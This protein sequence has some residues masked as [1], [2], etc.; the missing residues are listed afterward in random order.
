MRYLLIIL[1]AGCCCA[2]GRSDGGSRSGDSFRG[3]EQDERPYSENQRTAPQRVALRP[4]CIVPCSFERPSS[5]PRAYQP[6]HEGINYYFSAL[7]VRRRTWQAAGALQQARRID[8][9][10]YEYGFAPR[11]IRARAGERLA[12]YCTSRDTPHAITIEGYN[13]AAPVRQGM[14]RAVVFRARTAGTF[15]IRCTSCW[16]QGHRDMTATLVVEEG[17]HGHDRSTGG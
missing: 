7:A 15:T 4:A 9:E 6:V 12:L 11:C 17:N 5:F 16:Q 3:M 2:C 14:M 1:L 10:A 13:I 8:L